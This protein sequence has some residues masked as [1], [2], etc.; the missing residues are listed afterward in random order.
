MK[1]TL[2]EIEINGTVYVPKSAVDSNRAQAVNG[3]P[4][5]IIRSYGAG[6]FAGYLKERKEQE[7]TLLNARR[8]WQWYGAS[9]SELAQSGTPDPTKC[10]MP[11]EVD[12]ITV[13]QVIEIIQATQACFDSLKKVKIWKA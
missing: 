2:T 8:L 9:L 12:E 6:C 10:K 11:E 1:Q 13:L 4:Y 7:V 3:M 5:V